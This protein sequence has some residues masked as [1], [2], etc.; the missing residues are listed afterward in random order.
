MLG[1]WTNRKV[2][3]ARTEEV[4]TH[5]LLPSTGNGVSPTR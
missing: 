1:H 2:V 3:R 5:R 4:L